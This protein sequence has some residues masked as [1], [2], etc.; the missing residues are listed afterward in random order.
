V[1]PALEQATSDLLPKA[2]QIARQE[3]SKAPH[4]LEYS[5]LE[6]L[7]Y[8]GLAMAAHRWPAYCAEKGYDPTALEYFRPYATLRMRGAIVDALRSADWATRSARTRSKLLRDAGADAGASTDELAAVTGM[9]P[10]E[11]RANAAE[12]A[13][14]PVPLDPVEHDQADPAEQV[15]SSVL[16]HGILESAV[17]AIRK[18]PEEHQA[19]LALRYFY[20]MELREVAMRLALPDARVSQLHV[21]AVLAVHAVMFE[22]AAELHVSG[23]HRAG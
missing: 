8:T 2:Q 4:V 12:M 11:I 17:G 9:S 19:V 21:E 13:R 1:D 18:L 5:E 20:N 6:A 14:R 16:I 22:A 23:V 3:H 15:E 10:A 7:A